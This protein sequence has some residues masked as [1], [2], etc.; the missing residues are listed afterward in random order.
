VNGLISTRGLSLVVLWLLSLFCVGVLVLQRQQTTVFRLTAL[1]RKRSTILLAIVVVGIFAILIPSALGATVG[2]QTHIYNGHLLDSN[3][4]PIT[5]AHAIRFSYW[6]SSDYVSTD[7]TA[8]GSINTGAATYGSWQEVHTVTPNSRGYFS[9]VLGSSTSLPSLSFFSASTL[10]SLYLQVE[11]KTSAASNTAYELLDINSSSSTIDR[12]AIASVPFAL[13]ADMLD[14]HDVGTG[15]G[16]IPVLGSGGLLR[17]SM[18]PGGLNRDSF[19]IDADNSA[20]SSIAL[21]FGATLAKTLTYDLSNI[22]FDFN[23]SVRVQGNLTV[24]GLINGL[25][26]SMLQ[27]ASTG[28]LKVS[29]GGG[30]NVNIAY[31]SYRLNGAIVNNTGT[32]GVDVQAN[33]T[34][35]VFIG[36]GGLTVRTLSFP[37]D[38]GYIPLAVVTTNGTGIT[39]ITD[40]RVLQNDDREEEA[41]TT[42][43]PEYQN[44]VLQADASD[45][46][47][48]LYATN[49]SSSLRN[50]YLWTSTKTSLQDYDLLVRFTLP[51]DFVRWNDS[52]TLAYRSTSASN[53]NNKLDIQIYDTNGS[54]VTLSGSTTS[55]AD[56]SWTTTHIEFSGSPTWT[57][58]QTMLL[59]LKLSAKDSFQMHVGDL[60]FDYVEFHD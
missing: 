48:Q 50:Y 56:T 18:I 32:G 10:S 49:D 60:M 34:N 25:S 8:T 15:S 9:V 13:N 59:R 53:S 6:T 22:R 31:G 12:A 11:V 23:D 46:V 21:Q 3:G 41:Q 55:L 2:P 7:V 20:T 43:H 14:Q 33:A 36:S 16:A 30:L 26:L 27:N 52:M 58:G 37:T 28:A 54:P 51:A 38:E 39:A 4:D 5:T 19:T 47:G 17:E 42:M 57:A 35:Y 45:N 29:S 44:V 40:R 24:S 1:G